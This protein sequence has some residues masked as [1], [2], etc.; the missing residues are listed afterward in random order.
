MVNATVTMGHQADPAHCYKFSVIFALHN[1]LQYYF[2]TRKDGKKSGSI[3]GDTGTLVTTYTNAIS[4]TTALSPPAF[5][6]LPTSITGNSVTTIPKTAH[7]TT[8]RCISHILAESS[9]QRMA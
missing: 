8:D 7:S 6:H 5:L 9:E 2:G 4:I 1:I 3:P